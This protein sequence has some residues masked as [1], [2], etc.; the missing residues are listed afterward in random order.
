MADIVLSNFHGICFVVIQEKIMI[1]NIESINGKRNWIEIS[2]ENAVD[3]IEQI[4]EEFGVEIIRLG[5]LAAGLQ[6]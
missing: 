4:V 1:I 5:L 2:D 3:I 6:E